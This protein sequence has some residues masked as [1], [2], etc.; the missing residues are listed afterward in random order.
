MSEFQEQRVNIKFCLKLGKTL[1]ETLEMLKEA[2]GDQCVGRTQC[3][4][5]FN[6]VIHICLEG[7]M[8][9]VIVL[10]DDNKC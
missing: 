4:A 9:S 10:S 8:K 7:E 3:Y 5:P 1:T 2:Y 6:A